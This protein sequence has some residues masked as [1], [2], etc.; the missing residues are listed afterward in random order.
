MRRLT[1][2]ILLFVAFT[3]MVSAAGCR[4]PRKQV[5]TKKQIREIQRSLLDEAPAPTHPTGAIFDGKIEL[6]GVD[7]PAK[8]VK[9][10]DT[11]EVIWY[12]RSI[13]AVDG[14]WKIFVHLEGAG[15]RSG[16][17]HHAVGELYPIARWKAGEVIRD[18]Q[19]ITIAKDFPDGQAT[20]KVGIYDV[21]AWRDSQQNT[22]MQVSSGSEKKISVD[23][24]A[25]LSVGAIKIVANEQGTGGAKSE[26]SERK[27]T[28]HEISG[29]LTLDGALDEPAWKRARSTR[30]FVSPR[31]KGLS[32][33][34]NTTA[35]LLWDKQNLYVGISCRDDDIWN[36]LTGR[37]ATLWEQ[38]VVEIYLDPGADGLEYVELQVSPTG[39]LFDAV[40]SSR[41]KPA[42]PEAAAKL[43]MEGLVAHID[44]TGS[45]NKRDDGVTDRSW[46]AEISIPWA[47][48]P[49]ISGPPA[50][51]TIWSMNL[52]RIDGKSPKRGPFMAAWA[53]AGGDFH[54]TAGFGR[55]T[56]KKSKARVPAPAPAAPPKAPP[57]PAT[58]VVPKAP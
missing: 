10:G 7:L 15:R 29:A 26:K 54:N 1:R 51:G 50:D 22:R 17:D 9:Q 40:F 44:A 43:Q 19:K 36:D 11:I 47:E 30:P 3:M 48:L 58:K 14:E 18:K 46:N 53:P 49:G 5:L 20:F 8:P 21:A 31:G 56:F 52:Y 12:W 2:Y 4:K 37:D 32:A 33:S 24:E 42:W 57:S 45:V 16:Y 23:G 41:R 38:D 39:A 27:H 13:Q 6:L 25:R 34:W 28:A 55:V 35:K